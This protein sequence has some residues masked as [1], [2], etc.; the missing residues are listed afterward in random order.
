MWVEF[1]DNAQGSDGSARSATSTPTE[2]SKSQCP[3]RR[4]ARL[5]ERRRRKRKWTI[6]TPVTGDVVAADVNGDGVLELSTLA[7]TPAAG[8]QR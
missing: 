3:P 1:H 6:R 7:A 8:G 4:H 2:S 5:P